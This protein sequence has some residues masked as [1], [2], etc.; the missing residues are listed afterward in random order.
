MEGATNAGQIKLFIN[1]HKG[2]ERERARVLTVV[3]MS[4]VPGDSK[5]QGGRP[6]GVVVHGGAVLPQ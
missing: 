4:S 2:K 1:S 6:C 3:S 5:T